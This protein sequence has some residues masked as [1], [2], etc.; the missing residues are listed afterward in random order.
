[1]TFSYNLAPSLDIIAIV[2]LS[3]NLTDY[4]SDYSNTTGSDCLSLSKDS[5]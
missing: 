2:G 1:M 3:F 5:R 4:I